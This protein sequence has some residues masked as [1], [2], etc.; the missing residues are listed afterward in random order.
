LEGGVVGV[1]AGGGAGRGLGVVAGV[2]SEVVVVGEVPLLAKSSQPPTA[3]RA[4]TIRM[5]ST[6][7]LASSV[8]GRRSPIGLWR[9]IARSLI[10][11][12]PPD[13]VSGRGMNALSQDM[14]RSSQGLS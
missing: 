2:V 9:Q 11:L 1:V 6:L 8:L 7:Q 12:R 5:G 14:F 10:H 4:T 13:A 3:R